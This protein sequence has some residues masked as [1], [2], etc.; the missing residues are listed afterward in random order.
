MEA[1]EAPTKAA[2]LSA[3]L[4]VAIA[5][6]SKKQGAREV[7][8]SVVLTALAETA[9][10]VVARLPSREDRRTARAGFEKVFRRAHTALGRKLG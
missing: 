7:D 3:Y 1:L 6:W 10:E 5:E 2:P 8:A 9:G 4:G